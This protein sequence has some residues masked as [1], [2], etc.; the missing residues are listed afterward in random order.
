MVELSSIGFDLSADNLS[1][2]ILRKWERFSDEY[3]IVYDFIGV[4]NIINGILV[5]NSQKCI[6]SAVLYFV[7]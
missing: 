5:A 6:V 3:I 7:S 1:V 2:L 4:L